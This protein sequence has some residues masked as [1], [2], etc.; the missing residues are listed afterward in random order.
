MPLLFLLEE[1]LE[2]SESLLDL[3]FFRT[4]TMPSLEEKRSRSSFLV[5]FTGCMGNVAWVFRSVLVWRLFRQDHRDIAL[6]EVVYQVSRH[7]F[8]IQVHWTQ[9]QR[10]YSRRTPLSKTVIPFQTKRFTLKGSSLRGQRN[11]TEIDL[12]WNS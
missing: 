1:D 12:Y 8:Y 5:I 3:S 2:S 6:T 7:A 9:Q 11:S 10:T 4:S